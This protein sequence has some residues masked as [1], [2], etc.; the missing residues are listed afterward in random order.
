MLSASPVLIDSCWYIGEMRERRNPM[1]ELQPNALTR[2]LAE[3]VDR[4]GD[5]DAEELIISVA[6]HLAELSVRD[7]F[8]G[9]D[10]KAGAQDAVEHG[11][12]AAP[13]QMAQNATAGVLAGLRADLASD[14]LG[15]IA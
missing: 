12:S 8:D 4:L 9:L 15:N 11:R 3:A 14:D 7:E 5:R 6:H 13:L 2:D 10:A 1:R